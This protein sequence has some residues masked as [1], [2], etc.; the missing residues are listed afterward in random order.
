MKKL[1]SFSS[2]GKQAMICYMAG[3]Q[4]PFFLHVFSLSLPTFLSIFTA[5]LDTKIK[6]CP[7]KEKRLLLAS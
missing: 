6:K 3:V 5:P 4:W 7:P 2:V 1:S